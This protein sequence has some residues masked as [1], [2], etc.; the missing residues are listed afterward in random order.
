MNQLKSPLV[1][2]ILSAAL[3]SLLVG[4]LGDFIIIMVV[5]VIDAVLGFIQ[6]FQAQKT[7]HLPESIIETDNNRDPQ[8]RTPG[9][10]GP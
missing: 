1:Y 7:Y 8:R 10:R 5:V 2:I 3:I 6:E 4:E 9:D